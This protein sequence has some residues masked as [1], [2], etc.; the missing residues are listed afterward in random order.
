MRINSILTILCFILLFCSCFAIGNEIERPWNEKT[1][2]LMQPDIQQVL[3]D[4]IIYGP[5]MNSSIA[6]LHLQDV[7]QLGIN[8]GKVAA[9][10]MTAKTKS[11][12]YL[13]SNDRMYHCT[14]RKMIGQPPILVGEEQNG[15]I[16]WKIAGPDDYLEAID[17]TWEIFQIG[18]LRSQ[19]KTAMD[20]AMTALEDS[21][22][23]ARN[24]VAA[25][26]S[27]YE[28]LNYSGVC[29][30]AYSWNDK[31][32][33][34]ELQTAFNVVDSRAE[35]SGY[36]KINLLQKNIYLLNDKLRN[37]EANTSLYYNSMQLVWAEDGIVE[38][39]GALKQQA[40]SAQ[41]K[42]EAKYAQLR[43]DVDMA[44]KDATAS[45]ATVANE[46]LENIDEAVV[47]E[48]FQSE[49][50]GT[51][52]ERYAQLNSNKKQADNQQQAAA[53]AYNIRARS[54][55]LVATTGMQDAKNSYEKLAA[56]EK[57]LADAQIVV[58]TKKQQ[59][60]RE[61]EKARSALSS[62]GFGEDKIAEKLSE[63][64]AAFTAANSGSLGSRYGRYK[65]AA[66]LAK[67]AVG[68]TTAADELAV[69]TL[70]ADISDLLARAQ[71]DNIYI[72]DL[73]TSYDYVQQD[74]P[75]DALSR[76]EQIKA[77]IQNRAALKYSYLEKKRTGLLTALN[78][79]MLQE[80]Q[81]AERG[82]VSNGAI[83]YAAGLGRLAVLDG[84]YDDLAEQLQ[85]DKKLANDAVANQLLVET[86]LV[87][88][89]VPL[90]QATNVAFVITI[91]N[92]KNIQGN[93]IEI[94]V[95]LEGDFKFGYS[96]LQGAAGI[97]NVKTEGKTLRITFASVAPFERK[98]IIFEKQVILATS[99]SKE[100]SAVGI[101]A[102]SAKIEEKTVFLLNL[103]GAMLE[104]P[105]DSTAAQIDGLDASRQ[106]N[107]GVH[108]LLR[109]Y[110]MQGAYRESR[111]NATVETTAAGKRISYT[112]TISAAINLDEIPIVEEFGSSQYVKDI[113]ISC[114]TYACT[115]ESNGDSY[116]LRLQDVEKGRPA[117]VSLS[118]NVNKPDEYLI[119]EVQ[120]YKNS[121]EEE[122]RQLTQE[123]EQLAK[124]GKT[125]E[126][127]KKLEETKQKEAQLQNDK[128]KLLKQYY[129]AARK[130]KKELEDISAAME[131]AKTLNLLNNSEVKKLQLRKQMLE[132]ATS[133]TVADNSTKEDVQNALDRLNALDSNWL[134]DEIAAVGKQATK[135]FE[136]Y[137]KLFADA[138]N[139]TAAAAL[140]RL[141]DD[142]NILLATGKATDAI[143]V[144]A[145]TEQLAELNGKL[146][147]AKQAEL[148]QLRT[149]FD[150]IKESMNLLIASYEAEYKDGKAAGMDQ[151]FP[152]VPTTVKNLLDNIEKNL[153]DGDLKA[154]SYGMENSLQDAAA[155]MN[156]TLELLRS[157]AYGKLAEID[158]AVASRKAELSGEQQAQIAAKKNDVENLVST[159]RYAAAVK[160]ANEALDYINGLKG[161]GNLALYLVI[162]SV[163]IVALLIG[164]MMQ[165]NKKKSGKILLEKED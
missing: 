115:K 156:A 58:E 158:Q 19:W 139:A 42:A 46:G 7:Q 89:P 6:E 81:T 39:F 86:A 80:M 78:A 141:Q 54:Y 114:G 25:A 110:V 159:K 160:K 88:G 147:A 138:D 82:I 33:C 35:E 111:S 108:T 37:E 93:E 152:V 71:R 67:A 109:T 76:L 161:T 97:L 27:S 126:A 44:K 51:L 85:N 1:W 62:Q 79:A 99:R 47:T 98:T 122:V 136:N 18:E 112:T 14:G 154:A 123:T 164:Y 41:Q 140:Q 22:D 157:A 17:C 63:A 68:R 102:G 65:Q 143:A 61:I 2:E 92:L 73:K 53:T 130:A 4:L 133:I 137:K 9:E 24:S 10:V 57:L 32:P 13:Y 8:D 87:A 153:D 74:N 100:S 132:A 128:S 120:K 16:V 84:K 49:S 59:A 75:P 3:P 118:Y 95:P 104:L 45:Y 142:I 55:L 145:D 131:K 148:Q 113:S 21:N 107:S 15:V 106:L 83:D 30:P 103:D 5:K 11:A 155:K 119:A 20:S 26:G 48:G 60:Q 31:N 38:T 12:D 146:D 34:A 117:T 36:G 151:L 124:T 40:D 116:V 135:D 96:D 129:D 162:A 28:K 23:A 127:L 121:T 77:E 29:D 94:S 125:D 50:I 105:S 150:S 72:V 56:A 43:S 101:G 144:L 70:A 91:R 66:E 64:N 52:A 149:S 163:L 134:R 69:K 90:D 165:Q